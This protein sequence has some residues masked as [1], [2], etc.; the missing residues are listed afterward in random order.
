MGALNK[1]RR[2]WLG[3]TVMV[4][5]YLSAAAQAQ[6]LLVLSLIHI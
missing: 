1:R 6:D 2:A 4:L 5:V 3:A